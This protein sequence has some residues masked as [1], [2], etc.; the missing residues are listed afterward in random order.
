MLIKVV[1]SD[2]SERGSNF[3]SDREG[4][5]EGEGQRERKRERE[6]EREREY[7]GIDI[8]V[9]LDGEDVVVVL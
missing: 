9:A 4:E 6:N 3:G 1:E 2:D 7:L 5:G 8:H